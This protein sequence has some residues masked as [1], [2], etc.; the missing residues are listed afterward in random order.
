MASWLKIAIPS[1]TVT[2]LILAYM[3]PDQRGA[4]SRRMKRQLQDENKRI[5]RA[6]GCQEIHASDVRNYL[7]NHPD[8]VRHWDRIMSKY[9]AQASHK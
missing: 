7:E 4:H 6:H 2:Y 5:G 8:D 3:D 1:A 9:N